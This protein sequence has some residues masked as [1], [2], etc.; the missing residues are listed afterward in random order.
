MTACLIPVKELSTSM[1]RL[2]DL[3]TQDDKIALSLAMLED[4]LKVATEI[5][6]LEPFVIVTRDSRVAGVADSHD[7]EVIEEP[8]DAKG[9]EILARRGIDRLL[10]LPSDV[11]QLE[12]SDIEAILAVDAGELSVVM[13]PAH[14]GG[15]NAMF[16]RPPAAI[17]SRFGPNSLAL[18]MQ[19]AEA[20]GVATRIIHLASLYVDID[21][22]EDMASVLTWK[23]PVLTR[24]FVES[25]GLGERLPR[26]KHRGAGDRVNFSRQTR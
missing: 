19:E 14:D 21:T 5:S 25:I 11:P 9:E 2:G 12:R 22:P 6:A 4:V 24:A 20:R 15:T 23:G 18:H 17:P 1:S 16:R 7:I 8:V 3:L 26:P 10:V 13:A